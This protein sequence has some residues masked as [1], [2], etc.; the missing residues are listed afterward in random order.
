MT[1]R[2]TA[3]VLLWW[4]D[5]SLLHI[6]S[7][8]S[9]FSLCMQL[10]LAS[11]QHLSECQPALQLVSRP[12]QTYVYTWRAASHFNL[13]RTIR[14]ACSLPK[15]SS[16]SFYKQCRVCPTCVSRVSSPSSLGSHTS[17]MVMELISVIWWMSGTRRLMISAAGQEQAAGGVSTCTFPNLLNATTTKGKPPCGRSC[18][19]SWEGMGTL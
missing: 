3:L 6:L 11:S 13:S 1:H 18:W 15:I 7:T 16:F 19:T 9:C 14:T 10:N 4:T 8:C 17:T 2:I 5:I 12:R